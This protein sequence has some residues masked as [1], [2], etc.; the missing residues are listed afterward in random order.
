MIKVFLLLLVLCLNVNAKLKLSP[1]RL[2]NLQRTQNEF[3]D[4]KGFAEFVCEKKETLFPIILS[5]V[6][7]SSMAFR[8]QRIL[9]KLCSLK[10][11]HITK[12]QEVSILRAYVSD[13]L[14]V[15]KSSRYLM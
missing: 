15:D 5:S 10:N 1:F 7:I 6:P 4:M 12:F 14:V 2:L 11:R 3:T 13:C 8:C 9:Q